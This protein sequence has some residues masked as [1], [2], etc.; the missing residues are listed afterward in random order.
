MTCSAGLSDVQGPADDR[1]FCWRDLLLSGAVQK[2]LDVWI[3]LATEH[4]RQPIGTWDTDRLRLGNKRRLEARHRAGIAVAVGRADV[5]APL[6]QLNLL[7][8]LI[9]FLPWIG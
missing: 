5:G 1:R 9:D 6:R 8:F 4:R 3:I 2:T 7:L